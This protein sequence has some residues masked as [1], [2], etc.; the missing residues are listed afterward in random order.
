[1]AHHE[2]LLASLAVEAKY[3]VTARL[4]L[5]IG[6]EMTWA[7][8]QYRQ[9]FFGISAAQSQIAD[10]ASYQVKSGINTVG[11]SGSATYMLTDH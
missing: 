4:T 5:S 9:T 7:N 11:G 3:H 8:T 10:I 1:M 6:P 2:G